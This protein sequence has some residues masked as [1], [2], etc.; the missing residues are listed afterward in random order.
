MNNSDEILGKSERNILDWMSENVVHH[1]CEG[2]NEIIAA[3]NQCL[4]LIFEVL[5]LH[6]FRVAA[7]T[8][9]FI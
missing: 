8:Y 4:L 7:G 9:N 3:V 6:L 2:I 5:T 1:V